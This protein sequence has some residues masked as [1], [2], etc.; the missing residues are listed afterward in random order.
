MATDPDCDRI[1]LAAPKRRPAR[2]EWEDAFNGNQICALLCRLRA[3]DQPGASL[4]GDNFVIVTTLVTTTDGHAGGSP[5]TYGVKTITD[6]LVG[7]KWIAGAI[8]EHGPEK[9][10]YGCEES[11]GYMTGTYARDKDGAVAAMLAC[12]LAAKLKAEGQTLHTR[13]WKTCS[14][15]TAA[16]PSGLVNV[17][18]PGSEGMANG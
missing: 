11:H 16:T 15:S 8:D 3:G 18:M 2:G 17:Q 5:T 12:E 7:F 10:L 13:S 6:L 9:F 14:G 4:T 1:G